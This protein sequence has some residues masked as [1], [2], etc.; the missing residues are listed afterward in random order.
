MS[1]SSTQ[2]LPFPQ[3][4]FA[5]GTNTSSEAMQWTIAEL[6]NH[7]DVFSK[8]REEIK[9]AV[10][11]TRLV[12]ES[13]V[14]ILPYLQAVV[15]EALRLHPPVPVIIREC[16]EACKIK[17]FYIPN[18]TMVAINVYA[19]MRDAKIWDCPNDFRPERFLDSSKQKDG[20]EYIPFGAG[21]RAVPGSKLALS[22]VHTTVAAM[23][24]CFDWKVDGKKG[25]NKVNMQ[26]GPGI[27][28]PMAQPFKCLPVVH[29]NPFASS[30]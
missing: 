11:S 27:S 5:A 1:I 26:V 29:Y 15:K 28:M 7:P 10:G 17:N 30:M 21:R 8:V 3:D 23:V 6:I 12:G 25:D 18:K 2:M 19:I 22:L 14:P 24:Q 20:M 16:R 9:D 4:L 13:D